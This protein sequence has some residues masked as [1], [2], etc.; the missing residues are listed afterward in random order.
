MNID[1]HDSELAHDDETKDLP[2]EVNAVTDDSYPRSHPGLFHPLYSSLHDNLQKY[3]HNGILMASINV[4]SLLPKIEE[5]R[6]LLSTTSMDLLCV[7]ETWLDDSIGDSEIAVQGYSVIRK[8]RNRHG[9]GVLVFIK[10]GIKFNSIS[11]IKIADIEAVFLEITS[12]CRLVVGSLYR[13]PSAPSS[14]FDA[15]LDCIEEIRLNHDEL[16]LMGDLNFDC[17]LLNDHPSNPVCYLEM[18]FNLKQIVTSETR[19]TNSSATLIDVILTSK[20]ER[21]ALTEVLKTTFSDHFMTYTVFTAEARPKQEHRTMTF[22]DYKHFD[23]EAFLYDLSQCSFLSLDTNDL[24]SY[25]TKF[26]DD[27][28]H[29]SEKHAPTKKRRLKQR[30]NPW[31]SPEIVKAM[32]ARDHKQKLA[33]RTGDPNHWSSYRQLRNGVTSMI[34]IAKR[35]YFNNEFLRTHGQS[36]KLMWKIINRLTLKNKDLSPPQDITAA[37]FN[38]HFSSIG[39][40]TVRSLDDLNAEIP[41]KN[42]ECLSR[43]SFENIEIPAILNALVFLGADSAVDVLG[44]DAKLLSLSAHLIA[45]C[46]TKMFNLS[47]QTMNVLPDWKIARVTPLFKGK[48][49]KHDKNNYRPI[50]VIGHIAKVFERQIQRQLI[51][52]LT[53]NELINVDQSAYRENHS[54]QTSIIRIQEDCIDNLCDK[55]VTGLCFLDI[56]KCFDTIN[57]EVLNYK[58]S[59]YGIEGTELQWFD[60]YLSDRRQ[61]VFTNGNKSNEA[62]LNI[63]VPQGSVLGPTLFMLYV[64]DIS[65]YVTLSTCNLYADD[66]VIYCSGNN[67]SELEKKLQSSV[68]EV[69]NWYKANRLCINSEKSNVLVVKSRFTAVDDDA[70]KIVLDDQALQKVD[71]VDYLG[72]K[73]DKF[74]SWELHVNKL[75][76]S[77]GC[78]INK[79]SRLRDT[80]PQHVLNKIY[81][82]SIQPIIDYA[83][84]SWGFTHNYTIDKVQRLQNYASRI[85][86]GN[87]DYVHS[88]GI[89]IVK[90]LFWMNV[91]QRRN[92]FTLLM[93]FKCLNGIAP[94]YLSHYV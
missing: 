18:A 20:P 89:D 88:R 71:V 82:T 13:P 42:P 61:M 81:V 8:D 19:V 76:S 54:T 48:G 31:I 1:N 49:N 57:H 33:R 32:Y 38:D 40:N 21:H 85:V 6:I 29:V 26:K 24:E 45:P 60:N 86:T 9:G 3:M 66:T 92:Y 7:C 50:A 17:S 43:F 67:I 27:F 37:D 36:P 41:W 73:M 15:I 52:Y 70:M 79:L 11:C 91:R 23:N 87:F 4:R 80:A 59:H 77:L 14:Y 74:M 25:W 63:G 39:T 35:N 30:Y 68:D 2:S 93:V 78:Q 34:K 65:Q 94:R 5:I 62:V 28:L 84:C 58:L 16:I 75:C 47:L 55:L 56:R 22:K 10:D 51:R 46:L 44:F 83:I 12:R 53:A 72:A 90:S 69:H 64:N